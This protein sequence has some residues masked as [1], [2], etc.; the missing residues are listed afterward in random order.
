MNSNSS[1]LLPLQ[2][3]AA[4]PGAYGLIHVGRSDYRNGGA[5]DNSEILNVVEHARHPNFDDKL[6][7]SFYKGKRLKGIAYD[8]LLLK[9]DSQSFKQVVTLDSGKN[10]VLDGE[11]LTTIGFGDIN[12]DVNVYDVPDQLREATVKYIEN[13]RCAA[14]SI[15]DKALLPPVNM[16]ATGDIQDGC[17]G[18][19]G[20]PL[21]KKRGRYDIQV[22]LISWG[23]GCGEH[24]AVY[25]RVSEG[26]NWIR[27]Q[28][29]EMSTQPPS[30]FGCST[31]KS[32]GRDKS[33]KDLID[34]SKVVTIP[35]KPTKVSNKDLI[36]YKNLVDVPNTA[37]RK[38]SSTQA[39]RPTKQSGSNTFPGN[40]I[41][42]PKGG[43]AR[44]GPD[45]T[46]MRPSSSNQVTALKTARER[47]SSTSKVTSPRPL[48]TMSGGGNTPQPSDASNIF[49][50]Q[51]RK[52]LRSSKKYVSEQRTGVREGS[53]C[54]SIT[55]QEVCC[56]AK[57][58][59]DL[60]K[61]QPCVPSKQ[62][63]AF[64]S[65]STCEP[66]GWLEE[67]RDANRD[68][69]AGDSFSEMQEYCENLFEQRKFQL[70]KERPCSRI[71]NILACCMVRDDDG[72][73]CI[74]SRGGYALFP[75]GTMCESSSYV[76]SHEPDDAGS[77]R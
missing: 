54:R 59:S 61:D 44:P 1:F 18:D 39:A 20:G 45:R 53:S 17:Q 65:G 37:K 72:N 10:S 73:P 42:F 55:D 19:S 52:N 40:S 29:C 2:C 68:A 71:D 28:V 14:V 77:C 56:T 32:S 74:P 16:C 25:A 60:Y 13:E 24:P 30:S 63:L 34:Y 57:D 38:S 5:R 58:S 31:P 49:S 62:G 76:A 43:V 8:F 67:N 23:V 35:P 48:T 64:A 12:Y 11:D 27:K 50:S 3:R 69:F 9:L 6:C 26:Y 21:L 75:T 47:P 36:D 46:A 7:G 70:P 51:S 22:G 41:Y 4:T 66:I 33:Y 15:F